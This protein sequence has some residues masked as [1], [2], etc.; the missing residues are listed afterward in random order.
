[1]PSLT[2]LIE[3]RQFPLEYFIEQ[4]VSM[5]AE[6]H[7]QLGLPDAAQDLFLLLA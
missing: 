1:V 2:W 7:K 4:F 6:K 3:G 5:L